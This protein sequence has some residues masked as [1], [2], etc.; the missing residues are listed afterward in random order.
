MEAQLPEVSRTE[1]WQG[2]V[3]PIPPEVLDR[4]QLRRIARKE[5][6]SEA[7][8]LRRDEV[9]DQAA[10]VRR[11]PVPDQDDL[12]ANMAEQMSEEL[13]D[14]RG[15]DR[16]RKQAKVEVPDGHA[17]D[18][19][20]QVPVEVELKDRRLAFGRPRPTPVWPLRQSALVSE[21]DRTALAE[22]PLFIAGQ[23]FRFQ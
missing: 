1:V 13:H 16:A 17:G 15:L 2:V 14:L 5:F 18:G 22:S 19:R 7:V 10:P 9:L 3:F 23:R 12:A 21:D 6:H 11:Q 20:E 8:P 4:I